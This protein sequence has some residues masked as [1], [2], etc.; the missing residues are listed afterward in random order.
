MLLMLAGIWFSDTSWIGLAPDVLIVILLLSFAWW[1]A[2]KYPSEINYAKHTLPVLFLLCVG[3]VFNSMT[4]MAFSW[5]WLAVNYV[6]PRTSISRKKLLFVC[7]GAFPWVLLDFQTIGWWFRLSGAFLTGQLF[8]FL[9]YD[10][11]VEGTQLSIGGF[12]MSVE[13]ACGGLQL[14]QVLMSGGIALNLICYPK[15]RLFW[16]MLL[17]LPLLAWISNTV[18]IVVISAWGLAF[19]SEA[20][21]G[22]FHTW[23]AMVV[24]LAMV[25]LYL[26][27][28]K[29]LNQL[30]VTLFIKNG[31]RE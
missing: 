2:L 15:S 31:L 30:S 8:S 7:A 6:L 27:T 18:R 5:G 29:I 24:L 28:A 9:G 1:I 14:L 13:A 12:P 16:P 23:G 10:V 25:L 19:G 3:L 4:L 20:A 11:A 17:I 26:I 21:A 22:I